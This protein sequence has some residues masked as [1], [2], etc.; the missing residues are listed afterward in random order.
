MAIWSA[1]RFK[2]DDLKANN[3]DCGDGN[4]EYLAD[5]LRE[6]IGSKL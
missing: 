6:T 3:L 1:D 4:D 2:V 5:F